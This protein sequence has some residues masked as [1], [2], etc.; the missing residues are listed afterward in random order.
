MDDSI[1]EKPYTDE[2]ELVNWRYSH[3]KHRCMKGIHLM[4]YLVRYDDIALPVAFEAIRQS[5]RN[6]QLKMS[7]HKLTLLLHIAS[8][9]F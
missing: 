8:L 9:N 1:A 3:A 2:N 4:S 7:A 5:F 6:P